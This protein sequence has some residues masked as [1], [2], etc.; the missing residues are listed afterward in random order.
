VIY[1]VLPIAALLTA[2]LSAIIGMG[3]GMLLLATMF[4]FMSHAE[5]I[6]AHGAVQLVSNSTRTLAFLKHV[7][8][9]TVGRFLI[10]VIPGSAIGVAVLYALGEPGRSD[11][12]LKLLVGAY[13][14]GSLLIPRSDGGRGR[15]TWWDFPLLG[16]V[17]GGAAFTVG[18]VGPLIAPLFARRNFVKERLVATKAICQSLLHI[19]KI[20]AFLALRSYDNLEALGAVTL[21][22]ALLVIPGTLLGKRLLRHVSERHFVLLYRAALLTAGL[23]VLLADAIYPLLRGV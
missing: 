18:A 17:A 5:A 22:M 3:G 21:A 15:P 13:I 14:L 12:W 10:G 7:D 23:K 20:P 9:R 2:T 6:P 1:I 16:V 4:C 19:A 11:P 8:W